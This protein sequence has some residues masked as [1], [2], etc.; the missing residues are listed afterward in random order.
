MRSPF[1]ELTGGFARTP[2]KLLK[3]DPN[4]KCKLSISI[5]NPSVP[6]WKLTIEH[7][8]EP[9][10]Q[11]FANRGDTIPRPSPPLQ[12]EIIKKNN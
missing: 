10:G 6:V 4:H 9:K 2:R 3:S 5:V 12:K 8:Y 11:N 1:K 7:H